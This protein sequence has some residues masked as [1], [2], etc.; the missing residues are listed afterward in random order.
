[1]KNSVHQH[2]VQSKMKVTKNVLLSASLVIS[3]SVVAGEVN[4]SDNAF[5]DGDTLTADSLNTKFNEIKSEINDNN[6][7][8]SSIE[9][10]PAAERFVDNGD[11][12]ISDNETG[13]MWEKKDASDG[14]IDNN[15]PH[16]VDNTYVWSLDQ[17]LYANG[18]IITEFLDRINNM[19]NISNSTPLAGYTDWRI[20]TQVELKTISPNGCGSNP[21]VADP[22][23]L[24]AKGTFYWTATRTFDAGFSMTINFADGGQPSFAKGAGWHVRAVRRFRLQ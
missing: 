15:N 1:M 17:A 8:L 2:P 23:F 12:T 9:Q 20:P 3:V 10:P 24:P 5:T 22:M 6:S 7:R 14:V 11:G 13:L 16:D 4:Y 19:A 21:C 18:T